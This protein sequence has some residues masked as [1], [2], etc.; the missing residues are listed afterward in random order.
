MTDKALHDA[1]ELS[2]R[3]DAAGALRRLAHSLVAHRADSSLLNRIAVTADA[4]VDDL[5]RSPTRSRVSELTSSPRFARLLRGGLGDL[6]EDG[7]FVDLFHDSPISGSANPIGVGL[8][9]SRQNDSAVGVVRLGPAFEGAPQRAH[10]GIVAACIDETMGALLPI[11][12]TMAFT[13]S[14]AVFYRAPCPLDVDLEFRA[15]L[16]HRDGRKLHLRTTGTSA[17]G[18][19]VEAEAVF[20]AVDLTAATLNYEEPHS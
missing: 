14:L 7:A 8:R 3:I 20:I 19:F 10:G 1:V 11:I 15:W 9:L 17:E 18:V 2:A 5:A 13:G 6:I 12:G 4:W 16:D